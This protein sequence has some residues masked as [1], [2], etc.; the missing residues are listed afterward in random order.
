MSEDAR[1]ARWRLILGK[2][3][4]EALA[5]PGQGLDGEQ[6]RL[7]AALGALYEP[8]PGEP[9]KGRRGGV[10]A[11]RGRL[12]E[13]LGEIRALFDRDTVITLQRDAAERRGLARL[14][15]E[16]EALSQVEPSVELLGTL[17]S[18]KEAVPEASKEALRALVR[19]VVEEIARWLRPAL[20]SAVRGARRRT[21]RPGP[22][23]LADLDWARTIRRNLRHYQ[24][25]RRQL[26]PARLYWFGRPRRQHEW[27]LIV[28]LDQSGSMAESVVYGAVMASILAG[29]P[30]V[31]LHLVVF[32]TEVVDL[33]AQAADPVDVLLG[34]QL[35]GGTDI[36]KALAYCEGLMKHPSRTI[37]F[38]VSD[39]EDGVDEGAMLS[40]AAALCAAGAR[41][42]CL[43]A[44]SDAG[45][46]S[47]RERAAEALRG[48][49]VSCLACTPGA[50]PQVLAEVLRA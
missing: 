47:Y 49:G 3:A 46:P 44:L 27:T 12:A 9:G 25:A 42:V 13:W 39:L 48:R 41:L 23:R 32:D 11:G 15:L 45:A 20:T 14:L 7:D 50:L 34:V 26:I 24:P 6:Q 40:R 17:L 30:A 1:R 43:L 35:G 10:E 22:P 31:A 16:P 19:R 33:S 8:G 28:C 5:S 2:R 18:L 29:I 37:L 4:D 38:L 21:G 36:A